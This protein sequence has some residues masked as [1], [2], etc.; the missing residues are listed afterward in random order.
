M[1]VVLIIE[2]CRELK[3]TLDRPGVAF[4]PHP[5]ALD[6]P[7]FSERSPRNSSNQTILIA[8]AVVE[9]THHH[10]VPVPRFGAISLP[11]LQCPKAEGGKWP[12]LSAIS[13][14]DTMLPGAEA[15]KIPC[16]LTSEK[17]ASGGVTMRND[18]RPPFLSGAAG[19]SL[20]AAR[21]TSRL[22]KRPIAHHTIALPW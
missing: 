8:I 16:P 19:R 5:L 20:S 10:Q 17:T 6:F 18:S 14:L 11:L 21:R 2:R 7:G 1:L 3:E 13:N 15:E 9:S 4:F 12:T 22:S